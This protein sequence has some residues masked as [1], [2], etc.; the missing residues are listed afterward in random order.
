MKYRV[1]GMFKA[2][3]TVNGKKWN[4]ELNEEKGLA[5]TG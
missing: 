3:Y 1:R 5:R 2:N 4:G